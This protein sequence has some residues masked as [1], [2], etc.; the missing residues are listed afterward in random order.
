MGEEGLFAWQS[1]ILESLIPRQGKK[2]VQRGF[3]C[4][5]LYHVGKHGWLL[6]GNLCEMASSITVL[7][8]D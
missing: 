5:D 7:S 4:A 3:F 2:R 8:K 1:N 6:V